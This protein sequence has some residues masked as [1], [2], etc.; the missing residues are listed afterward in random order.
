M[1]LGG[2]GAGDTLSR[3]PREM[4]TS[5]VTWEKLCADPQI[6]DL[7]Y[8]IELNRFNQIVM[9]PLNPAHS[10][11]QAM[12][13]RKLEELM[14]KGLA[15]VELAIQTADR[16]KVPDVAWAS[17]AFARRMPKNSSWPEA[18]EICIEVLSPGNTKEEMRGKRVLF[19]ERGAREVWICDLEGRLTFW[20]RDP[21]DPEGQRA[22]RSPLCPEFP[23]RLRW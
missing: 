21:A 13:A 3:T 12:I 19:F 9:S 15:F 11:F 18:P 20:T 23:A 17:R 4:V 10:R 7:P 22:R 8:K 14:P 16:E 5:P 1:M 2:A 6:Q